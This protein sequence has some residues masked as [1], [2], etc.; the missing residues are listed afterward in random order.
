MRSCRSVAVAGVSEG[1]PGS[2]QARRQ[3]AHEEL[4]RYLDNL[5]AE[6]HAALH[7]G[8]REEHLSWFRGDIVRDGLIFVRGLIGDDLLETAAPRLR[9]H[10]PTELRGA[11]IE[12]LFL[13][14]HIWPHAD[15]KR[16]YGP[17]HDTLRPLDVIIALKKLDLGETMPIFQAARGAGKHKWT[18]RRYHYLAALWATYLE[19]GRG[20]KDKIANNLVAQAFQNASKD[21]GKNGRLP[22]GQIPAWRRQQDADNLWIRSAKRPESS[23]GTWSDR[24]L[25]EYLHS[26]AFHEYRG[27][28]ISLEE[29]GKLYQEFMAL[30]TA[31]SEASRKRAQRAKKLKAKE[32]S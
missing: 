2:L 31:D 7:S 16:G 1:M 19:H 14:G 18:E 3:R 11:L 23:Y 9:S 26:I 29:A 8:D 27:G 17:L 6:E 24:R 10:S 28:P 12:I 13:L 25:A 32:N 5:F 4:D 30:K 22:Q 15:R 20:I 21:T